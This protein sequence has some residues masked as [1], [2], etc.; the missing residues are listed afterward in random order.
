M[1]IA[2]KI[3]PLEE[4]LAPDAGGNEEHP[5]PEL[6]FGP[7]A[8]TGWYLAS[9][10]LADEEKLRE[11][12]G[13]FGKYMKTERPYLQAALFMSW[14]THLFVPDVVYG[15]YAL[16]R[17]PDVS[18]GNFALRLDSSGEIVEYAFC[19][20]RFAALPSDS[21]ATHADA[22]TVADFESLIAWMFE[23]MIERHMRPLFSHVRAQ[24]KL[25]MNVMWANVAT[26]CAGAIMRLQ[27]A[28]VFTVE[29][30]LAEEA[31]LLERGPEPLRERLSVYPL[32]S[33]DHQALFMRVE[34]CCQKHLH[35]DMGKCGYCALRP[36]PEQ[37]E[38]Q[39]YYFDRR[40]AELER[41]S[42]ASSEPAS[43]S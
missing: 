15:L 30:A 24:T 17:A 14:Y 2:E 37:R 38:M 9:D 33:G 32:T 7:P 39:Q 21:A 40:V 3:H 25:G 8:G 43:T 19:S 31:S 23:R 4:A 28:G 27:R 13:L 20:R 5:G 16:K 42:C 12:L 1:I 34:V 36:I 26:C 41:E 6:S 11:L 35:P 18:A 22:V 10:L 29:E